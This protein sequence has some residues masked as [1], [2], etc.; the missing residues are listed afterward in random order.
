MELKQNYYGSLCTEMYEI[1]HKKAPQDELEFYLSYAKQGEKILE[2]LC[3]SGRFLI[4]FMERGLHISGIDL[5]GEMLEKLKQKA[6]DAQVIQ[7][8][9][10]D[11]ACEEKFHYIFISSGSVSLFTDIGLCKT[12]LNKLKKLLL[13][14]GKLVFAVD[15]VADRCPDDSEYN[16]S[17]SVKTKEGFDLIL[18]NKNYYDEKSQTQFS[19][20]IYELYNGT[21][22]LQ[23]EPM[24]FQT[25]LYQFGEMEQYL[26][27]IGFTTIKTYSS[28]SKDIAIDDNC[29]MFLF[30]CSY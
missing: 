14:G 18:K 23:S 9:I 13:P 4:P 20:S 24:D 28:F 5:S 19:P 26:M 11:Y 16:V 25:H 15:T 3:G 29:E 1:L 2:P 22:L 8:D 6:S 21:E 7:A 10:T 12:I 30:E 17:V 27:E